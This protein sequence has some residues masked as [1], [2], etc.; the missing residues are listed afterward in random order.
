MEW[1][2]AGGVGAWFNLNSPTVEGVLT[3]T[4][5]VEVGLPYHPYNPWNGSYLDSQ[6]F[7]YDTNSYSGPTVVNLYALFAGLAAASGS[8]SPFGDTNG[9]VYLKGGQLGLWGNGASAVPVRKGTL[10][11]NGGAVLR[12]NGGSAGIADLTFSE[13]VRTNNATLITYMQNG[14]L[15]SASNRIKFVNAPVPTNG[16]IAPWIVA[17]D[18]FLTYDATAGLTNAVIT[19]NVSGGAFPTGLNDGTAIV[20]VNTTDATLGDNPYVNALSTS[21]NISPG[22]GNTITIASGGL[23]IKLANPTISA[24][25]VFSNA[26]G[27]VEAC[28]YR[29]HNGRW[30]HGT[31]SGKITCAGLTKFGEGWLRLSNP[32]NDIRGPIINSG[33][34]E[35][36]ITADSPAC[37]GGTNDVI[38]NGG[39]FT[40]GGGAYTNRFLLGPGGG[41]IES[42]TFYGPVQDLVPGDCGPFRPYSGSFYGTNT[43]SGGVFLNGAEFRFMKPWACP[44]NCPIVNRNGSAF[45]QNY[46]PPPG[47]VYTNYGRVT[48]LGNRAQFMIIG[49]IKQGSIEGSGYVQ[50]GNR[51]DG[52]DGTVFDVGW[53]NTDFDFYGAIMESVHGWRCHVT[54]SGGGTWTYWG[55]S[56]H[57]G[58][59]RITNGTLTLNGALFNTTNVTVYSGATLNGKGAIGGP[60]T[61]MPGAT[62]GGTLVLATN[63]TVSNATFNVNLSGPTAGGVT[64]NSGAVNITGSSLNV[65]L[66]YVPTVGQTF[67]ILNNAAGVTLTG[68]FTE[69]NIVSATHG[70]KT[71]FFRVAYNAGDGNDVT[72]TAL[73]QGTMIYVR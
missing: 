59:T 13:L 7:T 43:F 2:L 57:H 66:S 64:V 45:Y 42:T 67:T 34:G 11:I 37:I 10:T 19:H 32:N 31:I 5:A 54:K 36:P 30:N 72:L 60:V 68:T 1:L 12:L 20:D 70:G 25:L 21:Q 61:V 35:A 26:S 62:L 24:N 56:T 44:T 55:E 4:N 40:G 9:P 8:G 22:A 58:Y 28:I 46:A 27:L 69:G 38:L 18:G 39:G 48:L 3:G 6:V 47:A 29:A 65:A 16:V 63:L 51:W 73:P 15:G 14:V 71:Y 52:G 53:D 17:T 23:F 41:Y 50:Y 49:Y 33:C